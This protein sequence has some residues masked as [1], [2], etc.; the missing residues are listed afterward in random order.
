MNTYFNAKTNS[1]KQKIKSI[2]KAAYGVLSLACL[3][4]ALASVVAVTSVQATEIQSL[5]SLLAQKEKKV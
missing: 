2:K 4:A 5:D 1:T 3:G